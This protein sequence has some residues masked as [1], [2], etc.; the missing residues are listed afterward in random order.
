VAYGE[1]TAVNGKWIKA[2]GKEL[3][4]TLQR[5][6]GEKGQ[7]LPII[8]EDLG[9]ITPEVEALRDSFQFPGMKVLQF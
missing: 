7:N 9:V 2:P 4:K 1:K 8:A 6:L 5:K 3:F